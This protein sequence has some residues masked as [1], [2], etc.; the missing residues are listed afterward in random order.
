M[1][2]GGYQIIDLEG[3]QLTLGTGM[4]YE[5]LYEKIEGTRKPC[6]VS[7]I[8]IGGTEYHDCYVNF[9]VNESAFEGELYGNTITV[10]NTDV[11]TVKKN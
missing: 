8:N 1:N 5:G 10:E 11:V 4:Q 7:G 6:Y 9:S 2:K 3:K